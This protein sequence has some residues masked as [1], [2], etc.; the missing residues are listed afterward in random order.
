MVIAG[1]TNVYMDATT[2]QATEYFCAGWEARGF[3]RATAGG[4]EDMT[5]TLHGSRQRPNT[6]LLNEPLQPWSLR[7]SV[8]ACGMAQPQ[9]I[10]SDHLPF[11]LAL[12]GL[13]DTAGHAAVPV[14]YSHTEGR[15]LPYD[16]EAA[17]VQ[18][19]LLA[20]L[21]AAQDEPCLAPW[22]GLAEQHA[23]RSMPPAAVDKVFDHLHAAHDALARMVGRRQPS[24]AGSDPAA[25]A[26]LREGNGSRRRSSGTT[27]WQCAH[28]RRTRQMRPGMTSTPRQRCGSQRPCRVHRQGS[29]RPRRASYGRSWRGQQTP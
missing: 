17:P 27:P 7:A 18:R 2:N 14:P 24:L 13:L 1:D 25:G 6:F 3:Q 28:R 29:A 23:Y 15:L 22:L 10:G 21:T 12:P 9:V 11:R 5:P 4:M 16:A 8:G 26:L 20:A 19:S